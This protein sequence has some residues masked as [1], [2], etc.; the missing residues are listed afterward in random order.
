MKEVL[1]PTRSNDQTTLKSASFKEKERQVQCYYRDTDWVLV[2]A[3]KYRRDLYRL[4]MTGKGYTD[5]V[6]DFIAKNP[7]NPAKHAGIVI[8]N[9][10]SSYDVR[11]QQKPLDALFIFYQNTINVPHIVSELEAIRKKLTMSS[12]QISPPDDYR[13]NSNVTNN[14]RPDTQCNVSDGSSN[15]DKKTD[16]N[17]KKEIFN[18]YIELMRRKLRAENKSP[19]TIRN[20]TA[21]VY[22]FME[23]L[24]KEPSNSDGEK[25]QDFTLY[26]FEERDLSPG[27]VKLT[28]SSLTY[29]YKH[30]IGCPDIKKSIVKVKMGKHTPDVYSEEQV[31]CILSAHTNLKH[32]LI[33]ML[34]YGCGLRL[35]EIQLLKRSQINFDRDVLKVKRA[36]GDKHRSVMFDPELKRLLQLHF[37]AE[38]CKE[39]VF[40]GR[41]PGI[42]L[43]KRTIEK[44]Y[45][46]ACGKAGLHKIR[47]IHTLRHCFATHL[48]ENGVDLRYIQELLGHFRST[49]T[50]IYTHVSALKIGKI[51]S[52]LGYLR[53]KKEKKAG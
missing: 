31:A 35:E 45:E 37:Q 47:G 17:D 39:Y 34:A 42:E 28:N 43:S 20:Y 29:F 9:F 53:E 49:T 33:L 22:E 4:N 27:S 40:E 23:W 1:T 32:K 25:F 19:R 6:R 51:K 5:I 2:W 52:P 30:I 24:G 38:Q 7:G 48:L 12:E 21:H 44:I 36:K 14:E 18:K 16:L 3:R 15:G 46:N 41:T 50:E 26:L 8:G 10:I 11:L 13:N